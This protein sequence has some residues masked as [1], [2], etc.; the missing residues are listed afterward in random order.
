MIG[1]RLMLF[2]HTLVT[3]EFSSERLL[4][5]RHLGGALIKAMIFRLV[6]RHFD[7]SGAK[8]P[9]SKENYHFNPSRLWRA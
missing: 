3:Q 9:H 5:V 1:P 2:R 6:D 4:G 8:A 7:Q